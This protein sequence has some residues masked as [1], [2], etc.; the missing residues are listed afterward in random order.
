VVARREV[1][2]DNR[3]PEPDKASLLSILLRQL[4]D[5]I[6]LILLLGGWVV[7]VCAY[8]CMCMYVCMYV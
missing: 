5:F 6:V 7:Y 1:Y 3:T 4:M 8:V 2:G